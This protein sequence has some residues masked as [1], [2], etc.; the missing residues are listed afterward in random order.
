M[1]FI[2]KFENFQLESLKVKN[3]T[4]EDV[5]NCIKGGGRVFATIVKDFTGN[6]PKDALTPVS[7]D[8]DGLVTVEWEGKEYEI[9]LEDI[10]KIDMPSVNEKR[11][12]FLGQRWYT[13]DNRSDDYLIARTDDYSEDGIQLR[14]Y[15]L[16]K[17][18]EYMTYFIDED[19]KISISYGFFGKSDTLHLHFESVGRSFNSDDVEYFK[20]IQKFLIDEEFDVLGYWIGNKN[21]VEIRKM[22]KLMDNNEYSSVIEVCYDM[23]IDKFIYNI[24]KGSQYHEVRF[25]YLIPIT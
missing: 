23:T 22:K 12:I 21:N 2:K 15:V 18:E 9:D 3:I 19:F 6:D 17:L 5:I 13:I 20:T 7:I 10:E 24:Q 25:G 1:K 8:D 16:D 14:D 11:E 4:H